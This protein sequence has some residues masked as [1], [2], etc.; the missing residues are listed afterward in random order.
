MS[1]GAKAG[2][3]GESSRSK[4]HEEEQRAKDSREVSQLELTQEGIDKIV[5]DVLGGANGLAAI[6]AGEQS[7]GLY[8]SSVAANEA[9]DLSAKLVGE[10]ARLTGRQVSTTEED[11]ISGRQSYTREDRFKLTTEASGSMNLGL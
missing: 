7:S 2:T 10:I 8:N 3:E 1:V 9:G 6:F 4:T 5:A 11:E